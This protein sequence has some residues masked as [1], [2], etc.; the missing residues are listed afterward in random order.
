MNTKE[1]KYQ[2]LTWSKR[3][4]NGQE[5]KTAKQGYHWAVTMLLFMYLDPRTEES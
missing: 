5:W 4:V 2:E 1:Y 3:T